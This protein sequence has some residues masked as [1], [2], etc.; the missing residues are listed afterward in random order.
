MFAHTKPLSKRDYWMLELDSIHE[1]HRAIEAELYSKRWFDYRRFTSAEATYLFAY[2]Y[3]CEYLASYKRTRDIRTVDSVTPFSPSDIFKST[4]LTA[5][6]LARQAADSIGCRYAFYLRHIFQLFEVR[7]W[8][9]LPRPNQLYSEELVMSVNTAW[10][11]RRKDVLQFAEHKFYF[12]ASFISHPDQVAYYSWLIDHILM[13]ESRYVVLSGVLNRGI[14]PSYVAIEA[15]G[16][17]VYK[18]ALMF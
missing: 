7:G 11:Q 3:S 4:D 17:E 6:W 18:R 10:E 2:Y 8:K 14:F 16:S 1:D 12:A 5:M 9:H 13:R 15:F